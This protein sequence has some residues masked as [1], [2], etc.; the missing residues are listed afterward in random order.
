V[1]GSVPSSHHTWAVIFLRSACL[2]DWGRGKSVPTRFRGGRVCWGVGDL[3][4]GG[5][6]GPERVTG[7]SL[8]T[9]LGTALTRARVIRSCLRLHVEIQEFEDQADLRIKFASMRGQ[10]LVS[11]AGPEYAGLFRDNDVVPPR[12]FLSD[13]TLETPGSWTRSL[14]TRVRDGTCGLTTATSRR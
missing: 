8:P 6:A 7:A 9:T 5:S 13:G 2:K 10:R 11:D 1:G 12:G 14:S 4:A 3:C